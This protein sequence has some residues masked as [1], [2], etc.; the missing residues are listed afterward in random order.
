MAHDFL[1]RAQAQAERSEP[2]VRAAA[3]LRIAR[4]QMA[5]DAGQARRTFDQGL[6]GIRGLTGY[7]REFLFEEAQ[8]LAAAV[9]PGILPEIPDV[10]RGP[11]QFR[12][13]RLGRIML[14]YGHGDAAYDYVMRHGEPSTFPFGTVAALMHRLGDRERQLTVPR[15]AIEVWRA[16]P[17][18]HFGQRFIAVFQSAWNL[19][20]R[21]KRG[22][23]LRRSSKE[24]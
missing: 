5:F 3:L 4:V 14:D 16:A 19:L 8:M 11:Q 20:P 6:D 12:A 17:D 15:R 22:S 23:W 1:A 10:T 24:A 9:A 13:E 21:K 2:S 18:D 7:D